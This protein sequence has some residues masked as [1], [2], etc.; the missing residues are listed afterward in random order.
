MF[1]VK[2]RRPVF[3]VKQPRYPRPVDERGHPVDIPAQG[4]RPERWK[5]GTG[6]CPRCANPSRHWGPGSTQLTSRSTAGNGP[7]ARGAASDS[8]QGANLS[9]K[10]RPTAPAPRWW[11]DRPGRRPPRTPQDPRSATWLQEPL[12]LCDLVTH[13]A[14]L[15]RHRRPGRATRAASTSPSRRSRGATARDVT[16]SNVAW[17]CSSSARPRTTVDVAEPQLR[18]DLVE[19]RRTPQQRLDQGHREVRPSDGQRPGPGGRRRCR[20]RTPRRPPGPPH[21]ARPS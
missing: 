20:C 12:R 1:H 13:R 11:G 17:P 5:T 18:H 7:D 9:G 21:P 19:E 6:R 16:T 8:G 2:H 3:H 14:A 10:G 4:C 15:H